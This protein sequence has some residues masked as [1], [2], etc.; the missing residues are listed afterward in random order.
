LP[1]IKRKNGFKIRKICKNVSLFENIIRIR[2]KKLK[3]QKMKNT[4][5]LIHFEREKIVNFA[6]FNFLM[7]NHHISSS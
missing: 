4:P 3:I 6:G 7:D 5:Y 1:L 2:K